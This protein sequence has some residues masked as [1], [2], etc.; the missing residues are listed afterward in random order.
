MAIGKQSRQVRFEDPAGLL[1]D[2]LTGMYRFLAGQGSVL[3]GEDH[4]ADL[5]KKSRKGRPTL[6]ARVVQR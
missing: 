2:R 3:F 4:F 5:F 1:G 6:P